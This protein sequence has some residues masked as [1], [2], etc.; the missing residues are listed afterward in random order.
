VTRNDT[1]YGG[2]APP[3]PLPLA[4]KLLVTTDGGLTWTERSYVEPSTAP[5]YRPHLLG[6]HGYWLRKAQQGD[7][8]YV[9][10]DGGASWSVARFP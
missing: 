9:T 2:G 8:L 10:I 5:R 1:G 7:V 4:G 6:T 3:T